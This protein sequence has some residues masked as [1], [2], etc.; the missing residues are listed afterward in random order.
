MITGIWHKG[1]K[2]W[3]GVEFFKYEAGVKTALSSCYR[4]KCCRTQSCHK[5]IGSTS[6]MGGVG[7]TTLAKKLYHDSQ[8]TSHFQHLALVFVSQQFQTR[9]VWEDILSG[10]KN[11]DGDDRKQNDEAL[12]SKLFNLLKDEKCLVI[13][14]DIWSNDAWDRLKQRHGFPCR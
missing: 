7:K 10:F 12:A 4:P 1:I 3:K 6:G 2:G 8:V 9:K 5:G 13:L 11:L 14:D